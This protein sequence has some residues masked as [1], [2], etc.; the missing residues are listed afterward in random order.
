[1]NELFNNSTLV[2]NYKDVLRLT[3]NTDIY[4]LEIAGY[5]V[6]LHKA[7]ILASIHKNPNLDLEKFIRDA[8]LSELEHMDLPF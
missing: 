5:V 1:M 8:I 3:P 7:T 2:T 4:R 6:N